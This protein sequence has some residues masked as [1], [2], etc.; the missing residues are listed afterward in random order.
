MLNYWLQRL[1]DNHPWS[2]KHP[3]P[4]LLSHPT[5]SGFLPPT[6][7]Q[8]DYNTPHDINQKTKIYYN[9]LNKRTKFLSQITR[10]KNY[11]DFEIVLLFLYYKIYYS[12]SWI[13]RW[14][15]VGGLERCQSS[16][17]VVQSGSNRLGVPRGRSWHSAENAVFGA[18]GRYWSS[19]LDIWSQSHKREY[20][21]DFYR[22]PNIQL[23]L[24]PLG[25][26][27]RTTESGAQT[28]G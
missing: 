11:I 16:L 25:L 5:A 23:S 26:K 27:G 9:K 20:D 1:N 19:R 2:C 6:H 15:P 24:P 17:E 21:L 14:Y 13:W 7:R 3:P 12:L 8:A 22:E 28:L 18:I 10:V 4:T